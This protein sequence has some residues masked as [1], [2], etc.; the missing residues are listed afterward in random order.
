MDITS[1]ILATLQ[2][3][4][5]EEFSSYEAYASVTTA[6]ILLVFKYIDKMT[7]WVNNFVPM[8]T[9]HLRTMLIAE[10]LKSAMQGLM[11][12]APGVDYASFVNEMMP[13][14]N[15]TTPGSKYQFYEKLVAYA[16]HNLPKWY[17]EE[18]A[19]AGITNNITNL[20]QNTLE[21]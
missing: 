16:E 20:V 5:I 1:E 19:A 17:R 13:R 4:S 11:A 3:P 14:I 9:G 6:Q 10:L 15:W 2:S 7:T 12:G 18:L 21:V 8:K